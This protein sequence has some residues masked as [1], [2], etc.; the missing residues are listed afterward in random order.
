MGSLKGGD[1]PSADA[2]ATKR[3]SSFS[4][5]M[6]ELSI[7]AQYHFL[8]FKSDNDLVRF[9]PYLTAG[10]GLF[11]FNRTAKNANYSTV[12]VSIPF[13]GGIKYRLSPNWTLGSEFTAHKTFFDYL[14]N[15]SEE[16]VTTQSN[17]SFQFGNWKDNDWFY[18][19]G[20]SISYTF[21]NV[22]CPVQFKKKLLQ[23]AE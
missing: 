18:Y 22:N 15:I 17:S 9:S 5:F 13:G 12:Q 16:N 14:D 8:D 6:G 4:T 20:V 3:N 10:A 1:N 19:L 23:S 21:Y 11:T 7:A 2:L